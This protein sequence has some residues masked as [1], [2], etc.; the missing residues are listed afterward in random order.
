MSLNCFYERKQR[1]IHGESRISPRLSL[2]ATV[3][4]RF[5]QKCVAAATGITRR[6]VFF[7][8]S[9]TDVHLASPNTSHVVKNK[10]NKKLFFP[11]R[12]VVPVVLKH[13]LKK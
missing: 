11:N 3:S 12:P 9:P 13:H 4:V 8:V 10:Q 5:S 1:I 6:A 2:S 7:P